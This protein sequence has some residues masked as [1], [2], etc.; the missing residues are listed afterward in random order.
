MG[1]GVS[2]GHSQQPQ[3]RAD[4]VTH[5]VLALSRNVLEIRRGRAERASSPRPRAAAPLCSPGPFPASAEPL[6]GVWCQGNESILRP[7]RSQHGGRGQGHGP[8]CAVAPVQGVTVLSSTG[9]GLLSRHMVTPAFTVSD[10]PGLKDPGRGPLSY[11]A[12]LMH[13]KTE[14]P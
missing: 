9:Q 4:H 13:F 10:A 5:T 8:T 12:L 2:R 7:A 1:A 6:G 14:F 11:P 3:G